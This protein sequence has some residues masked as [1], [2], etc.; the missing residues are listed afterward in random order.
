MKGW[1]KKYNNNQKKI[2]EKKYEKNMKKY[3]VWEDGGGKKSW[4]RR[5]KKKN[6]DMFFEDHGDDVRSRY[7]MFSLRSL[8]LFLAGQQEKK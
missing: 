6:F 4:K 8:S 2:R 7:M 5:K 1:K 3:E